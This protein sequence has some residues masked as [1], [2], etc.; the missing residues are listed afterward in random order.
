[1]SKTRELKQIYDVVIQSCSSSSKKVRTI[2]SHKGPKEIELIM[3]RQ[4]F[5]PMTN[6]NKRFDYT[7]T[8]HG[9]GF[10]SPNDPTD[11]AFFNDA[12]GA[13]HSKK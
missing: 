8:Y 1:M 10:R 13:V 9:V 2:S 12:M 6:N 3:I 11:R 7:V 5:N 4:F